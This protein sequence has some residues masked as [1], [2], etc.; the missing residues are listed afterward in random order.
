M[1]VVDVSTL[2][3]IV[4]AAVGD[5][6]GMREGRRIELDDR[7]SIRMRARQRMKW[8]YVGHHHE[9]INVPPVQPRAHL[10]LHLSPPSHTHTR[11]RYPRPSTPQWAQGPPTQSSPTHA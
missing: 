1:V 4:V 10:H 8:A 11:P 3:R 7:M 5:G 2:V 9:P 6:G